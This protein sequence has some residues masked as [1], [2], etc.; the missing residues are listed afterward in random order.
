MVVRIDSDLLQAGVTL[1]ID[2]R[3]FK[4]KELQ[5]FTQEKNQQRLENKGLWGVIL[6]VTKPS[7][8]GLTGNQGNTNKKPR[9]YYNQVKAY[10]RWIL[11]ADVLNPPHTFAMIT[12]THMAS[13]KF[14]KYV[15]DQSLIGLSFYLIEPMMSTNRLGDYLHLIN[16]HDTRLIPLTRAGT[17]AR[18]PIQLPGDDQQYFYFLLDK[19][20]VRLATMRYRLNTCTGFQCDRQ[21]D[22]DCVCVKP[23]MGNKMVYEFDFV[24]GVDDDLF[25][26]PHKVCSIA[27]YQTMSFFFRDLDRYLSVTTPD[28]E[29]V[30]LGRRRSQLRRMVTYVNENGGWKLIGWCKKGLL[31]INGEVEKVANNDVKLNLS[32][33][34]PWDPKIVERDEFKMLQI[35]CDFEESDADLCNL[36]N[37]PSCDSSVDTPERDPRSPCSLSTLGKREEEGDGSSNTGTRNTFH[38]PSVIRTPVRFSATD[39]ASL[40]SLDA[41]NT[42][43]GNIVTPLGQRNRKQADASLSS[44]SSVPGTSSKKR[45]SR[46]DDASGSIK[47]SESGFPSELG[48]ALFCEEIDRSQHHPDGGSNDGLV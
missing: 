37:A 16:V 35:T 32:S 43:P 25:G 13:Y 10:H 47:Y 19:E 14:F 24:F 8:T 22:S 2:T 46:F 6:H 36:D 7:A 11:C 18:C 27:S 15:P 39:A 28:K 21:K 3:K 31:Q 45:D 30:F 38:P 48:R 42:D 33:I 12:S 40:L 26:S 4:L 5:Y 29:H 23:G 20:R 34:Y 9:N 1:S 17:P 41:K 44:E